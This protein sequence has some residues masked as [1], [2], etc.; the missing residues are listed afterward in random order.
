MRVVAVTVVLVAFSA[1][2][3]AEAQS[4][5]CVA[6]DRL[7]EA[8]LTADAKRRYNK[9]LDGGEA[10]RDCGI[11]G[12][13]NVAKAEAEAAK[14]ED[15]DANELT[16]AEAKDDVGNFFTKGLPWIVLVLVVWVALVVRFVLRN[17]KHVL[18]RAPKSSED[19]AKGVVAA[20]RALGG[21]RDAPAKII[22]APDE[23]AD[24][25]V[26]DLAKLFRIPGTFPIG[27]L[28][29]RPPFVA[30]LSI[31]LDVSGA[32]A[33]GWAV[34]EL[35]YREPLVGKRRERIA[36]DLGD[37][38]D[39]EK[40]ELLALV[41]GAWLSV[42]L[43]TEGVAPV[44]DRDADGLTD[45]ALFRAGANRQ[46]LAK[47]QIA[48]ACYAAMRGVDART[49]P[50]AWAGSRLNE[51]MA[52]KTERRWLEAAQVANKVGDFPTGK[53]GEGEKEYFGAEEIAELLLRQ[54]YMTAILRV[55]HWYWEDQHRTPFGANVAELKRKAGAAVK[56]LNK[57]VKREQPR[58]S[59]EVEALRAAG[60]MVVLSY[61]I[62]AGQG[63]TIED[64]REQL[65]VGTVSDS[66][67]PP[68]RAAG[69][70][71]A[72]CAVSLLLV[73]PEGDD[74]TRKEH[75][76]EALWLLETAVAA[77][78]EGRRPRVRELARTDPM[79]EHL[80]QADPAGFANALGEPPPKVERPATIGEAIANAVAAI[81]GG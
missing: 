24:T 6:G 27:E 42:V 22:T 33:G 5:Q 48:R 23:P 9:A 68:V 41:G 37:T 15:D 79:L 8:G 38:A 39:A 45:H 13:K 4:Q 62:A 74:D 67:R 53:I 73:R 59:D 51:M 28:L 20:A 34:I 58:A 14:A 44:R 76:R 3:V 30:W 52:L 77:T 25:S 35:T 57:L 55:D 18:V 75:I 40:T 47:T 10:G 64:I 12:L 17:Y 54:R 56:R 61:K 65:G 19:L 11:A 49:A 66:T 63:G 43:Q 32:I 81:T 21:Q 80:E 71:D 72:A 31:R 60:R 69:Y 2:A 46:A 1:G 78:L 50:F 7:L 70:Y 26:A 16:F 36:L 29:K